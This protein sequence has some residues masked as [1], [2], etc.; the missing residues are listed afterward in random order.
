MARGAAGPRKFPLTIKQAADLARRIVIE[1]KATVDTDAALR[2][3]Y[4]GIRARRRKA[5]ELALG[6]LERLGIDVAALRWG[7]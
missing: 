1:Q 2:V 4:A 5:C 6:E 3:L 7:F